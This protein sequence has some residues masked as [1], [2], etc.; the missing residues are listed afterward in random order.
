MRIRQHCGVLWE[1]C[2]DGAPLAIERAQH[3][4]EGMPAER[5]GVMVV[6]CMAWHCTPVAA[7]GMRRVPSP[8]VRQGP[9]THSAH[10]A[11]RSS[12]SMLASK[13]TC[14]RTCLGAQPLQGKVCVWVGGGTRARGRA[15]PCALSVRRRVQLLS[16][17]GAAR[18]ACEPWSAR[19]GRQGLQPPAAS[20]GVHPHA[21][22]ALEPVRWAAAA[23]GAWPN[24]VSETTT[25]LTSPLPYAMSKH[26]CLRAGRQMH[27]PHAPACAVGGRHARPARPGRHAR[28]QASSAC[29]HERLAGSSA[30]LRCAPPCITFCRW[31]PACAALGYATAVLGDRARVTTAAIAGSPS[32]AQACHRVQAERG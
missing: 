6:V 29:G 4:M 26:A 14:W 13:T 27:E 24:R 5:S 3:G 25:S 16:G 22:A 19:C 21:L 32:S 9:L 15:L 18:R 20:L 8:A 12:L 23:R 17:A 28:K 7:G 2:K 11:C 10:R 31:A 1:G 30:V